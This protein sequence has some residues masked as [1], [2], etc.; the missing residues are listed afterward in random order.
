MPTRCWQTIA[1]HARGVLRLP[2]SYSFP[3]TND[4]SG[5]GD[6]CRDNSKSLA[7]A[8]I[9]SPF[10][11]T[12]IRA[13]NGSDSSTN[14]SCS[15]GSR[16]GG[17]DNGRILRR[18]RSAFD[19]DSRNGRFNRNLSQLDSVLDRNS[20]DLIAGTRSIERSDHQLGNGRRLYAYKRHN[21]SLR[22]GRSGECIDRIFNG[23]CDV[24]HES[25]A[26]TQH[27]VSGLFDQRSVRE[28]YGGCGNRSIAHGRSDRNGHTTVCRRFR[29]HDQREDSAIIGERKHRNAHYRLGNHS[30]LDSRRNG[31]GASRQVCEDRDGEYNRHAN[32]HVPCRTGSA[33]TKQL[34]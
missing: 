19:L 31:H 5:V 24:I 27:G 22:F 17:R 6:T 1:P 9:L 12:G 16:S 20:N 26:L 28:L 34:I 2:V 13:G 7:Y 4:T 29:L 33:A 8:K 25:N 11:V 30:D 32:L 23:A 3:Q 14:G 15:R 21:L 18:E 10:C